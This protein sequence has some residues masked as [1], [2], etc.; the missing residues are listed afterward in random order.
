LQLIECGTNRSGSSYFFATLF[1]FMS[2]GRVITID[3]EKM[4]DLS[5]PCV[6]YLFGNSVA[7]KILEQ[8]AP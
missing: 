1:D 4:N 3:I 6:T 5:H 8:V 2:H 7:L